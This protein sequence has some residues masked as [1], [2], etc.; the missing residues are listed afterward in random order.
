MTKQFARPAMRLAVVVALTMTAS[1]CETLSDLDPTGL[2]GDDAAPLPADDAAPTANSDAE[3]TT[4]D[5]A[6][7]PP[8]PALPDAAQQGQAAQ[9]VAA[10]GAQ[11]QYSADALRAGTE[12][13]APPPVPASG[14]AA[15]PTAQSAMDAPPTAEPPVAVASAVSPGA[16]P[17]TAEPPSA[18][19]PSAEPASAEPPS[20]EV[21]SAQPPSAQ[22]PSVPATQVASASPPP[23]A[24]P[25]QTTAPVTTASIAPPPGAE[26]AVPAVPPGGPRGMALATATPSDTALGFKP[27]SAPPLNPDISNW[28]SA[29]ILAHYRQTAALAGSAAAVPGNAVAGPSG[30]GTPESMAAAFNGGVPPTEIIYFPGDGVNLTAAA[31]K[32]V[33]Q[34]VAAFKANGGTGTVKVV[35]HSSSRTGNMSV[36]RHLEVIF[37]KSQQRANAVA[38]ALIKAGIPANKVIVEA[39]GDGQPI[40][41][42]SMPRGEEGNRRAEIFL[43]S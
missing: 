34:A 32:K 8:R 23:A 24:T 18:A 36:E 10:A 22:P 38:Q 12:P 15:A 17:P 33:S 16:A 41:Y 43:Q 40:Y 37:Q 35:G 25:Q 21:P 28:V 4:P 42:E 7:L 1:A 29:P 30:A 31:R 9:Q 11:A 20:A 3:V 6:A 39:V 27:S 19:P 26:P 5:L 2:L 14:A 13:T